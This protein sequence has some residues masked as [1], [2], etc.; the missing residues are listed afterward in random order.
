VQ[1]RGLPG[2]W[3]I[4]RWLPLCI[5]GDQELQA[6][7]A[8]DDGEY[9]QWCRSREL[10]TAAEWIA[11]YREASAWP[12]PPRISIVTPTY[13]TDI[14]QLRE[15][16]E[17][18]R[19]QSYPYWQL[20]V[21]DDASSEPRV[22]ATLDRYARRDPRIQVTA[23]PRNQGI[24]AATN[25]AIALVR[26]DWVA[27]LDHDDRLAPDALH[28]LASAIRHR[29][30]ADVFYSDRDMI[31]AD[32]RR[33]HHLLK[34]AWSP[35][36]LLSGNYAF[37]L[38]SYR[39]KLIERLGGVRARYEGSQDYDLLLRATELTRE[40]WHIPRVLYH[41]RE[42]EASIATNAAAKTYV[43]DA[44]KRALADAMKRRGLPLAVT[45]VAGFRGHYRVEP[46]YPEQERIAVLPVPVELAD[47]DF[48]AWLERAIDASPARSDI[49]VVLREDL[50]PKD[51]E[52]IRELA[53]WLA[54]PGVGFTTAR[55]LSRDGRLAHAGIALSPAAE[56]LWL[57][58]GSPGTEP[59]YMAY[60]SVMRNVSVPHPLCMAMRRE[61]W[62]ATGRLDQRFRG[63]HAVWDLA[64]RAA[65]VGSRT[66]YVPYATFLEDDRAAPTV[67]KTWPDAARFSEKWREHLQA[68]DPC[69]PFGMSF[70]H[71]DMRPG[72]A[73]I[74]IPISR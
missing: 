11:L 56:P 3:R 62:L 54:L 61:A 57:Y 13:D 44:G 65:K 45:D 51:S 70:R 55:V 27:F 41:W 36:T 31:L 34:P 28:W 68:G 1:R 17:S 50:R 74:A 29:P 19:R 22:R 2:D 5:P 59:G 60:T 24:C 23:L 39:R 71:N 7:L 16:I 37:H 32:G 43:Y 30:A 12:Q 66:V 25:A 53:R 64:L 6:W 10:Q 72:A 48:A 67:A 33:G 18:V 38:V 15:C 40:V 35:E 49:L 73:T 4:L 47:E 8:C 69:F 42:H 52:A 26:G 14:N 9:E 20:C 63:P 58:R 21:V 46:P